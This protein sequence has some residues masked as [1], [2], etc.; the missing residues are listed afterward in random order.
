L[1]KDKQ[2][3]TAARAH[4]SGI[5]TGEV[6][7][8]QFHKALN[9]QIL[10]M[11]GLAVKGRLSEHMAWQWLLALGWRHMRVKKG[12]YMDGHERPDIVKYWDNVFLP[13]MALYE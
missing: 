12:M 10:P 3:Q 13:L 5:P 2:V 6:T 1:L 4:L 7:L 9:N 8:R 11:L